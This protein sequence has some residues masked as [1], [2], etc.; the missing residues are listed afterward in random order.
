MLT[1]VERCLTSLQGSCFNRRA[2]TFPGHELVCK[3]LQGLK[4]FAA[5]GPLLGMWKQATCHDT[6]CP[7]TPSTSLL[8][9]WS[10]CYAEVPWYPMFTFPKTYA[11]AIW[12]RKI[13]NIGLCCTYLDFAS[14]T[15]LFQWC[16]LTADIFFFP[17]LTC[18]FL[19]F[20]WLLT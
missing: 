14:C 5:R 9:Q 16:H 6:A 2:A 15:N 12:A 17:L 20:T 1:N 3:S 4:L 11:R 19:V 13:L 8:F 10:G 7:C 18:Y